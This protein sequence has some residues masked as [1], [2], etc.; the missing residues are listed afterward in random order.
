MEDWKRFWKQI[1]NWCRYE[2]LGVNRQIQDEFED[3]LEESNPNHRFLNFQAFREDF[4][5][6]LV[7]LRLL[8]LIK[9]YNNS[10]DWI[11]SESGERYMADLIAIKKSQHDFP[12][13]SRTE[14]E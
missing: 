11:L 3:K 10:G 7:Q 8:D 12:Q 2:E 1:L 5:S 4:K 6:V 13:K 9:P 14:T